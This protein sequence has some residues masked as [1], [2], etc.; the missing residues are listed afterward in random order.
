MPQ[1]TFEVVVKRQI[2]R[3]EAPAL[4]CCQVRT[5]LLLL[6][7]LLRLQLPALLLLLLVLT[8]LPPSWC[9]GSSSRS[10]NCS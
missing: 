9:R 5:M 2:A 1:E 4:E 10:P 8:P 3:L 6:L 7:L